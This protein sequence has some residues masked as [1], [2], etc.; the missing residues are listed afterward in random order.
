M[1]GISFHFSEKNKGKIVKKVKKE[2][3][4]K[5][6]EKSNFQQF[7]IIHIQHKTAAQSN[8]PMWMTRTMLEQNNKISKY[9][10]WYLFRKM[11]GEGGGEVKI[12]KNYK[13]QF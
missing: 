2:Q 8:P 13:N 6:R 9:N 3:N 7:S 10:F 12:V 11:R 4:L 5:N 1:F